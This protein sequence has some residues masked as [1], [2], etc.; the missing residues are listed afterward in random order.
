MTDHEGDDVVPGQPEFGTTAPFGRDVA[1]A[2]GPPA[3]RSVDQ[4]LPGLVHRLH[5]AWLTDGHL[6]ISRGT[7]A[8]GGHVPAVMPDPAAEDPGDGTGDEN[9]ATGSRRSGR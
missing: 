6:G 1:A 4:S 7:Q 2:G 5:V 3:L 8:S 9:I